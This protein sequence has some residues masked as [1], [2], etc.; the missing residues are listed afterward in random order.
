M[1]E[2]KNAC[3]ILVGKSESRGRFE[4]FGAR[5]IATCTFTFKQPSGMRELLL[6]YPGWKVAFRR[7]TPTIVD[8]PHR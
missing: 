3:K 5:E 1:G 8:V 2:M 4:D 6:L 7:L